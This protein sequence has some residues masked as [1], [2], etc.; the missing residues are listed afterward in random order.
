MVGVHGSSMSWGL[1]K[2][3]G[4]KILG[5]T[6]KTMDTGMRGRT[7]D[8][9]PATATATTRTPLIPRLNSYWVNQDGVYKYYEVILVE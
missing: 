4:W 8:W 5:A 3:I 7:G 1:G 6:M 2:G 9:T